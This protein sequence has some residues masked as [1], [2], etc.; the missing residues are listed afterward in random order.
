MERDGA[1]F[2]V[3]DGMGGYAAGEVA[4]SVAV[5]TIA[6]TYFEAANGEALQGL[7]QAIKDANESIL[8]MAREKPSYQGMGT[9]IVVA[10]I[11]QGILYVANIGDSRAYLIRKGRMRQITE[12]H[13]WVAEQ[14]RAG[15]LTQDQA[16]NHIHRNVITRSL[17]TQS[18]VVADVFVEPV[19]EGD[20]L[21]MCSDGLHGYVSD[22]VIAEVVRRYEPDAAARYLIDL[23]NEAGGPDNITVSIVRIDEMEEAAPELL[24][25]LQLMKG[26][27]RATQPTV[28]MARQQPPDAATVP[29]PTTPDDEIPYA[30]IHMSQP[31]THARKP[32]RG[33][34]WAIRVAAILFLVL[35]SAAVWDYTL[36]PFAQ[37]RVVAARITADVTKAEHDVRTLSSYSATDQLT[38]LASDTQLIRGD[39]ALNITASQRTALNQTLTVY[40]EPGVQMA[41]RTYDAEAHIVPLANV[42]TTTLPISCASTLTPPLIAV[43]PPKGITAAFVAR[44]NSG[45]IQPI[46]IANGQVSCGTPFGSGITA[47]A[48]TGTGGIVAIE[49]FSTSSLIITFGANTVPTTVIKLPADTST[50][51]LTAL[52]YSTQ[53]LVI[54]Q[55]DQTTGAD[56]LQIYAGPPFTATNVK[57]VKLPAPERS[58][59]FGANGV[60]YLLLENGQFAT[61]IPKATA[62]LHIVGDLQIQPVV[63]GSNPQQYTLATPVP[64]VPATTALIRLPQTPAQ[65]F[66]PLAALLQPQNTGTPT[67]TPTAT[68]TPLPTPRTGPSTTLPS[69]QALTVSSAALPIIAVADGTGHRVVM[70]NATGVDLA[71]IQQYADPSVLDRVTALA[72]SLDQHTLYALAGNE[73]LAIPQP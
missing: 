72:F 6:K 41:L 23:A 47:I 52:T 31:L 42:P 39:F 26:Q 33:A 9:T 17:G 40:L 53:A 71:L 28:I 10:V 45:Q 34:L 15:V 18:S 65:I 11:C 21:L 50:L 5:Q 43:T 70:L 51:T 22:S 54:V 30:A 16:R 24:A 3:A 63:S 62:P 7:A 20:I 61:Y 68:P 29:V 25:R 35:L 1:L 67:V 2:V 60:L 38:L 55:H 8:T 32:S 69:A 56:T 48:G 64:T 59:G 73:L 58:L 57:L 49:T 14:V 27:P 44:T 37:S 46:S 66:W 13:S 4:S 12:D 19:H 36:G